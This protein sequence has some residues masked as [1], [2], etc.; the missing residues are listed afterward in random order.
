MTRYIV[1]GIAVGLLIAIMVGV[2]RGFK[3]LSHVFSSDFAIGFIAGCLF[4]M[5][6]YFVVQWLEPSRRDR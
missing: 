1:P 5:A 2:N 3:G 6:L 4:L